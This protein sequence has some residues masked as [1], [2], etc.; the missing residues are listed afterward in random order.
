MVHP[1]AISDRC[2]GQV[3]EVEIRPISRQGKLQVETKEEMG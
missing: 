3:T 1:E 2:N